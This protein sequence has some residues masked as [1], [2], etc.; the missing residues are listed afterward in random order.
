MLDKVY[1]AKIGLGMAGVFGV[2]MIV[3]SA[4]GAGRAK[5]DET[6][7]T[8]ASISVPLLGLPFRTAKGDIGAMQKLTIVRSAPDRVEAFRLDVDLSDGEEASQF[9]NCEVTVLDPEHFD[10]DTRFVCL[11]A[12]DS[13]FEDLVQFGTITFS[14][15][16]AVHRLMI[17][18]AIRD[19]IQQ[20]GGS[21]AP[22][23]P[24]APSVEADPMAAAM[25]HDSGRL[26]IKVN[27]RDVIDM[28]GDSAGG[29]LRIV[30]PE[31][32][33]AVVEMSGGH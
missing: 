18:E 3:T 23:V 8:D 1:L 24:D 7:H 28:Q 21:A 29:S 33:E 5:V 10:K 22:A 4:I 20:S 26:T 16:G 6:L 9:N 15:S 30:N 13:G 32:G 14:P 2:G 12:A 19:Q 27:G 31:T 25:D 11:T 17:P